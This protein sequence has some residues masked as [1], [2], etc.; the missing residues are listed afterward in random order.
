[1]EVGAEENNRISP[2]SKSKSEGNLNCKEE[3]SSDSIGS[4]R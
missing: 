1:M 3:V 2:T 4:N